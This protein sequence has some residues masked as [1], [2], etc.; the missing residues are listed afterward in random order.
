M[1]KVTGV[2]FSSGGKIYFFDPG[3]LDCAEGEKVI[4]ETV[5]GDEMGF[6][7]TAPR[8]ISDDSIVAPLKR[9][10]RSATAADV[11]Q[12]DENKQFEKDALEKCAVKIEEHKL[13]MK[14]VDCEYAFDRS[15]LIFYF[16]SGGRV[17]FRELVKVLAQ[18]FKTRIELRQIGVR[19][20]AKM[21]GG[22]GSCGNEICCCRFLSDFQP[23]TIRMARDQGLSLNPTKISGLCGRLMC[24]LK[25]EQDN[26]EY[27]KAKMPKAGSIVITPD[28]EGPVVDMNIFREKVKVNVGEI[29]EYDLEEIAR[30]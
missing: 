2:R 12:F 19:D 17:D 1:A 28:G 26:Y 23:V 4:V 5:R 3:E 14:L 25:Y 7:A 13:D 18:I 11:A 10:I 22:I 15:K 16:T 6:V 24:C 20:E 29:R 8:E 27:M 30:K 21:L 9:V